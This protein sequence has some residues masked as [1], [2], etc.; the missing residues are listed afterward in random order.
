MGGVRVGL[1]EA[2]AHL[3]WLGRSL[4]MVDVGP[5]GSLGE[6]L[7]LVRRERERMDRAGEGGWVI[8]VGARMESWAERRWPTRAELDA[9]MGSRAGFVMSF[10][11]HA[12]VAN[13]A[14]LS[15]AGVSRSTPDPAGGVIGRDADGEPTGVMLEDACRVVRAAAPEPDEAAREGHVRSA[16]THLAGLGYTGVHDLLSPAW[17]GP[18][19]GAMERSGELG[20]V[21]FEEVGLYVPESE[22]AGALAGRGGWEGERVR[23]MGVKV[24]LDGTLNSRT[25]WV[26]EPFHGALPGLEC[27]KAMMSPG[28]LEGVMER[29]GSVGLGVA[30][31]AIGDGAVRGA[32]DAWERVGAHRGGGSPGAE[33]AFMAG[34]VPRLRVEH[35]EV[36]D[37]ADVG[38]FAGLGVVCGVQPCHL[39]AD[40]EAL[41]RYLPHRLD[42]VLPLRELIDAGCVPGEL[43]WFGSD[44]PI[45]GADPRDSIRAAVGRG[46][47]DGSAVIAPE[48]AITAAEAWGAFGVV[49]AAARG[50]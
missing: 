12:L 27:G 23:L 34:G 49:G 6:A 1:R 38:R 3:P 5:A 21:G 8:A 35:C 20:S 33:G 16:L 2:H 28:E 45:V 37:G 26:L 17:L 22:A 7:G 40:I 47:G 44:A 11:Y 4:A 10:D 14:A 46:R 29:A 42:R 13:G 31:H 39:L 18:M 24:F 15:A 43:L 25:A 36:V 50:T 30:V 19:L 41:T 32:L 9:A 48:Q